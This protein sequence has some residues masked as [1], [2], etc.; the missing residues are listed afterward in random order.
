[1][2]EIKKDLIREVKNKVAMAVRKKIWERAYKIAKTLG[3]KEQKVS[4]WYTTTSYDLI[5]ALERGH[6]AIHLSNYV[7]GGEYV[8]ISF[9]E[10]GR[11]FDAREVTSESDKNQPCQ[12]GKNGIFIQSYLPGA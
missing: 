8:H 1:M 10:D 9:G 6:L 12:I 5:V 4:N 3:K 2:T 11:V 7:M